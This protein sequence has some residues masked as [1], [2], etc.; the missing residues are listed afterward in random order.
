MHR[1]EDTPILVTGGAGFIGSELVRQLH[2]LGAVVTVLDNFSSGADA[3]L[4]ELQRVNVVRGDIRDQELV[5][6]L[7]KDQEVIFNLAAFP[8]IPASYA[9]PRMTFE[10]NVTGTLNVL[11]AATSEIADIKMICHVSTSEVYGTAQYIPMD[12]K[13]PLNPHSTYAASKLAADRLCF[14]LY[15]EQD[16]PIV[17]IRPFNAYGPRE[18]HPYIIPILISQLSRSDIL[19]LGNIESSRDFTYVSD[20]VRGLLLAGQTLTARGET[21]NLG[22]NNDIKIK[23]LTYL[24]ARLKGK[25]DIEINTDPMRLRPLDV[26][27]LCCSNEKA[28]KIL[29]WSPQVSLEEGLR[30][31][32]TWFENN[33]RKWPWEKRVGKYN[34]PI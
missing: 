19:N 25:T 9:Y 27:R 23:D 7:V 12:E 21:I 31:T 1:Y 5:K 8:F 11:L 30:H 18:T 28:K 15:H 24:I 6:E 10:V 34:L 32:I 3:N 16:L 2:E 13:H 22:S 33:G 14:T 29:K 17:I 26:D 4:A 20:T